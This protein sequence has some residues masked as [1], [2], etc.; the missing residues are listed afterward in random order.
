MKKITKII[1]SF[2]TLIAI[3]VIAFNL[4]D[5]KVRHEADYSA[6]FNATYYAQRYPDL[7][8]AG[9]N[10]ESALLNHFVNCGMAEGRQ[11]SEEFNVQAYMNRYADLRQAFGNDLKMYYLHYISSG[12]AEGR[13]GKAEYST[14]YTSTP[15]NTSSNTSSSTIYTV[16]LMWDPVEQTYKTKAVPLTYHITIAK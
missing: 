1:I 9:L 4:K 5:I 16:G 12:K 11:G 13:N 15:N 7:V 6:V 8:A 14:P 2:V 10:N 3:T